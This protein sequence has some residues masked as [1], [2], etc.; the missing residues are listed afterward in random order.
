[1]QFSISKPSILAVIC[2]MIVA[3][4]LAQMSYLPQKLSALSVG[5]Q[6]LND[7][8]T[9][10]NSK[11]L[12]LKSAATTDSNGKW[13]LESIEIG[14]L[15]SKHG[16][17]L[18]ISENRVVG[19]L[20]GTD[21]Y[22]YYSNRISFDPNTFNPV[23]Y[24]NTFRPFTIGVGVSK[25]NEASLYK[26]QL[27]FFIS[28]QSGSQ[29][30]IHQEIKTI[31]ATHKIDS[32]SVPHKIVDSILVEGFDASVIVSENRLGITYLISKKPLDSAKKLSF[33]CGA[34][35]V[36]GSLRPSVN[37][38]YYFR[39]GYGLRNE[40]DTT[41]YE[42]QTPSLKNAFLDSDVQETT[43]MKSGITSSLVV[44]FGVSYHLVSNFFNAQYLDLA[45]EAIPSYTYQNLPG[46]IN[47]SYSGIWFAVKLKYIL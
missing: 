38:V 36:V 4:S 40:G 29:S 45:L 39:E 25:S 30:F 44:P 26:H 18:A 28:Q 24:Q 20:E 43:K 32:L 42:N 41:Y 37:S 17:E 35:I 34:G 46:L 2:F 11:K 6:F 47:A 9:L 22:K 31:T 13:G 10:P 16:A 21:F 5:N 14:F 1:M 15:V 23:Y 12:A 33:Y 7:S 27:N 19:N 8:L 3:N